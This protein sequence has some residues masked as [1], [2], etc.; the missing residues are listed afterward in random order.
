MPTTTPPIRPKATKRALI[1]IS[2]I[3]RMKSN[4]IIRNL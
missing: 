3:Q 2:P 1:G 4:N